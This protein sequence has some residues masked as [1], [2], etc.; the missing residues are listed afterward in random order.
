MMDETFSPF[1]LF[2]GATPFFGPGGRK[3]S[4]GL[5]AMDAIVPFS[6]RQ[7]SWRQSLVLAKSANRANIQYDKPIPGYAAQCRPKRGC[8]KGVAKW[9]K[10]CP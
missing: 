10:F 4:T 1:A 7:Q 8:F 5:V 2:V 9:V 6:I 3:R